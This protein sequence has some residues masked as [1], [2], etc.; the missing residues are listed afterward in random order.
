LTTPGSTRATTSAVLA[1]RGAPVEL[2]GAAAVVV[3]VTVTTV[4]TLFDD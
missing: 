1:L 3:R 2:D 4:V